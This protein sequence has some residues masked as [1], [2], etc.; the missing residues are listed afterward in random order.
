MYRVYINIHD[1]METRGYAPMTRHSESEFNED[2]PPLEIFVKGKIK[3]VVKWELSGKVKIDT[4]TRL[5]TTYKDT[6]VHRSI[7]ITGGDVTPPVRAV[8]PKL[9]T[10]GFLIEIFSTSE[11]KFNLLKHRLVPLHIPLSMEE[12]TRILARYKC[13]ASDFPRMGLDDPVAKY[14]G[15]EKGTM[16]K[17]VRDRE[18]TTPYVS[19]RIFG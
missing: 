10:Q 1:M 12:K 18:T 4:I 13:K 7:I 14:L 15:L 8:I 2:N 6:D 9:A 11:L 17:I 16:V 3:N 5:Y 19:Y